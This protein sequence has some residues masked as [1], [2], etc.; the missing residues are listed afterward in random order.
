MLLFIGQPK[1]TVIGLLLFLKG[2]VLITLP[3]KEFF[4]RAH[5]KPSVLTP[6]IRIPDYNLLTYYD[7]Q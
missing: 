6:M 3:R 4:P 5:L 7:N 2:L 1:Y